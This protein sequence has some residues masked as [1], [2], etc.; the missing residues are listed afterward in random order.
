MVAF[1]G[2][3][4]RGDAAHQL[5]GVVWDKKRWWTTVHLA[6]GQL[7]LVKVRQ[8][9][10]HRTKVLLDDLRPRFVITF[11][12]RLF[13]PRHR[14]FGRQ[15]LGK[16]EKAGLHDGVDAAPQAGFARHPVGIHHKKP[17][18]AIEDDPLGFARQ[19][20]PDFVW[21]VRGVEQERGSRS[22]TFEHVVTIDEIELMASDEARVANQVGRPDPVATETQV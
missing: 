12:D 17:Q 8:R 15:H 19:V 5:G 20:L 14:F 6:A 1:A 18:T 9:P 10:I 3:Q 16:G 21:A 22:R 13:D 4:G 11:G 2:E 7:N